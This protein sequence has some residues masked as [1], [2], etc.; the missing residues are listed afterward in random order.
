MFAKKLDEWFVTQDHELFPMIRE[1]DV[2]DAALS[3]RDGW[4]NVVT[5]MW[6][7]MDDDKRF[8]ARSAHDISLL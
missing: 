5:C 6:Y 4:F 7:P 8:R 2:D 1:R 3:F